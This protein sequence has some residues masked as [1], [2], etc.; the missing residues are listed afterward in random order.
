MNMA[1]E[2]IYG[3]RMRMTGLMGKSRSWFIGFC[4]SQQI[5]QKDLCDCKGIVGDFGLCNGDCQALKNF[6]G[7]DKS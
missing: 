3:M 4:R 1:N 6:A 5:D 2:N 7:G